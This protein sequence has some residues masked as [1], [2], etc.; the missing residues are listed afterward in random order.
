M[1][2]AFFT[3]GSGSI[4]IMIEYD[5]RCRETAQAGCWHLVLVDQERLTSELNWVICGSQRVTGTASRS[6]KT[7][8]NIDTARGVTAP[9][10]LET[11]G[12]GGMRCINT[13]WGRGWKGLACVSSCALWSHFG[14]TGEH[15]LK[16]QHLPLICRHR[17]N[18]RCTSFQ[19]SGPLCTGG[20]SGWA[21]LRIHAWVAAQKASSYTDND[22]LSLPANSQLPGSPGAS[23]E[24]R[25]ALAHHVGYAWLHVW[26]LWWSTDVIETSWLLQ[27]RS[28]P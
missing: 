14:C 24:S 3:S 26:F 5:I 1:L 12:V 28:E 4:N 8:G 15:P 9:E 18:P 25:P 22:P 23:E 11:W 27:W 16:L 19:G 21:P 6:W 7:A 20:N 2:A 13:R 10:L 17:T